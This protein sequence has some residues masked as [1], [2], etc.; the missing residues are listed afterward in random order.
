MQGINKVILVGTLGGDPETRYTQSGQ[1]VTTFSMATNE[2]WVKDGQ[3]QERTEWHKVVTFGKLAE[4][5]GEYLSKGRHAYV[6]G[7][8]QKQKY[9]KQDGTDGWDFSIIA[10]SV[11]FLPGAGDGGGGQAQ[12]NSAPPARQPEPP[13]Q[14]DFDDDIPF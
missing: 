3:K 9:Q 6:E 11:Q 8:I 7:K 14:D 12:R 13:R 2:S 1:P 10:Q 5:C 4:N